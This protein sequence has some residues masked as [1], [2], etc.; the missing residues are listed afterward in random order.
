MLLRRT[1]PP[2]LRTPS[3]NEVEESSV[4]DR[5]GGDSPP[6]PPPPPPPQMP[7]LAQFWAALIAAAPGQGERNV[8]GCSSAT[9]FRHNSPVFD[10]N[11]GSLAADNWITSFEDLADA[12]RCTDSQK[13]DYAGLKLEGEARFWW[14]A[15]KMGITEE[16]GQGVPIPWERFKREFNDR[17]FP[18]TQRQQ[19]AR[20]FQ[21]LKQGNMTVERYAAEFQKLSR[22]A[23]YLIP[24]EETKAERFRDGL[25]ARI[26]ERIIYLN[27]TSYVEMV[28]TAT[29]AERGIREAAAEYASKKRTMSSGTFSPPPPPKRHSTSNSDSGST[30]RR[31]APTS[32]GSISVSQCSKCGRAHTGECLAKSITC[33]RCGKLGHFVRQCPNAA[34]KSQG[35]Q[36]SNYQLRQPAQAR[37]YSLT[38]DSVATGANATDVV[39]G[40]IPLFGCVACILFD[41]GATHSFISSAY[42]K[43]CQL[44]T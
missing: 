5:A 8:V 7:D 14:K 44:S 37:V 20:E 2:R 11:E 31:Y 28:H 16:L 33:F 29:L 13:V 3:H 19:C 39:T 6:P 26:R 1:M 34:T 22:Y 30:G 32:R 38:P 40:T 41:S 4:G 21:D 10:G 12:V 23:P 9:F 36:A 42:V 15:T 18:R 25:S 43:L 27:I 35:S 17:F 24:D